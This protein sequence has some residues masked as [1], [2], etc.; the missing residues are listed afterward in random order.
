MPKA[1]ESVLLKSGGPLMKIIYVFT[2][3]EGMR[4]KSA[5]MKGFGAGDCICEWMMQ[6]GEDQFKVKK[7]SFKAATLMYPDGKHLPPGESG[8]DDDDW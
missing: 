8:G 6:V 5:A 4:E 3:G 1:G 2:D 7:D